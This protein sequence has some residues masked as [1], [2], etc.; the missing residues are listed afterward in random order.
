M[1][2]LVWQD[3]LNTGIE[4]VDNQHR[5][6]VEMINHLYD[7]EQKDDKEE[8]RKVLVDLVD[9]T[10]SH[11]AFEET[12]ME[13]AGY[14]F[15]RAHK[16]VHELFIRRVEEYRMRFDAGENIVQELRDTL[17]RWLLSHIRN[18]DAAYAETVKASMNALSTDQGWLS[19]SLKKFFG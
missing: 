6:I 10:Q 17:T 12:L 15:S 16:K 19:R 8:L 7:V 13:E 2:H 4:E 1:A 3:D 14:R 5:R 9:Y 11:F 18:E